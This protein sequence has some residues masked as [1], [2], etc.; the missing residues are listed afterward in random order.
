M[1]SYKN[2]KGLYTAGIAR[3]IGKVMNPIEASNHTTSLHL[4]T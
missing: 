1:A 3:D 2:K 4:I